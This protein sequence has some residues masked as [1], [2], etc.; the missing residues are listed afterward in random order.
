[1][2]PIEFE[3][4]GC[5]YKVSVDA[6]TLNLA[7]RLPDG[8]L[9]RPDYWTNSMLPVPM[10]LHLVEGIEEHVVAELVA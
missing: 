9:I 8:K 2:D 7:I 4:E 1:M 6:Y 3:F 10:G 5:K